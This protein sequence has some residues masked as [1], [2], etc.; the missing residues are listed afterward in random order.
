MILITTSD[1]WCGCVYVYIIV[2][3]AL[4]LFCVYIDDDLN[5]DNPRNIE[6]G[7]RGPVGPIMNSRDVV[8]MD[9]LKAQIVQFLGIQK[10]G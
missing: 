6:I 2:C 7:G 8:S 9:F 3:K 4:T 1:Q 10:D 5:R